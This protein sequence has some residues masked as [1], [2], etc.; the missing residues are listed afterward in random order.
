MNTNTKYWNRVGKKYKNNWA[1]YAQQDLSNKEMQLIFKYL[2]KIK[3]KKIIDIGVGSGRIIEN[4]VDYVNKNDRR[5]KIWG[6][7]TSE[8]MVSVCKN[9]FRNCSLIQDIKKCDI[10]TERICFNEKFNFISAIRVI[11]Y[12]KNWGEIIEK[13]SNQ[14][15]ENGLFVFTIL[16][17]RS[18]DRFARYPVKI[19]RTDINAIRKALEKLG[20]EILE[21]RGFSKI[22]HFFYFRANNKISAKMLLFFENIF[23]TLL[24]DKFLARE[25][26]V[27][28]K[29]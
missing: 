18:I 21:I 19:Y 24:G 12:N 22:P 6:L 29:K 3:A 28:C 25:L 27:I 16:N 26:Y 15:E 1:N 7:D 10:S 14:L 20:L 11:K 17:S 4:Y 9:K 5:M 13:I 8:S 2:A 23:N